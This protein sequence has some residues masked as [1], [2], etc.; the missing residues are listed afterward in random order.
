MNLKAA[1]EQKIFTAA[2]I[3]VNKEDLLEEEEALFFDA[4][5]NV[6]EKIGYSLV[7][8]LKITENPDVVRKSTAKLVDEDHI[9]LIFVRNR[10]RYSINEILFD[11]EDR[12]FRDQEDW[13][14]MWSRQRILYST[15]NHAVTVVRDNTW[16]LN[17]E[18]TFT[19]IGEE[20]TDILKS[21]KET[22]IQHELIEKNKHLQK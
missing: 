17:F 9:D 8:V 14:R 1:N 2:I 21:W 12:S 4:I 22:Y 20:L 7:K 6:T 11:L 5:H 3:E 15:F 18:G 16:I 10:G 19:A 13:K